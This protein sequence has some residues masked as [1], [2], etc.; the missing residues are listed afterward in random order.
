MGGAGGNADPIATHLDAVGVLM[1]EQMH[2]GDIV[3]KVP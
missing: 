2:P 3:Q 1:T